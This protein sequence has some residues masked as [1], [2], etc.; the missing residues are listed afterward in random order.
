LRSK[1]GNSESTVDLG[2]TRCEWGKARY[3]EVHTWE[4]LQVHVKLAEISIQLTWEAEACCDARHDERDK[5][6][7]IAICWTGELEGSEAY[8]IQCFVIYGE[9]FVSRFN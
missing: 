1:F 5:M 8:I 3:V 2:T 9:H 4:G 6:V 7:Q